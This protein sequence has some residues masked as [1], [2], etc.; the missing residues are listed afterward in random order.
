MAPGIVLGGVPAEFILFA[1][2]LLGVALFHHRTLAVAICGLA[3]IV[4]YK[5]AITGFHG[6]A[7]LAG[8]VA[9]IAGEWVVLANLFGLLL[10]RPWA[11]DLRA[12]NLA[13]PIADRAFA[14]RDELSREQLAMSR[15]STR[16]ANIS[17]PRSGAERR[18]R[19][20]G[21]GVRCREGAALKSKRLSKSGS[22][23]TDRQGASAHR[24]RRLT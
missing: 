12:L 2:T 1:L 6:G 15:R 5:V 20:R 17:P 23:L 19:R 7:G 22:P 10:G 14:L 8:L 4:M 9:H 24:S 21:G 18:P 16:D 3:S 13:A 11:K